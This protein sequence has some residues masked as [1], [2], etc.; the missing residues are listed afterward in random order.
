LVLAVLAGAVAVGSH[1]HT[2]QPARHDFAVAQVQSLKSSAILRQERLADPPGTLIR[3][4]NGNSVVTLTDGARTALFNGPQREFTEPS[5]TTA[6][7]RTNAYVRLAPRPWEEGGAEAPWFQPWLDEMLSTKKPDLLEVI[8]QYLRDAP[9]RSEKSIRYRGDASFG[10]VDTNGVS[11][12]ERSDFFQYLGIPYTFVDGVRV[13]PEQARYG[14]VDSS[15]FVRL[16]YGY[17]LGYPLLGGNARGP[18]LPRRAWAISADGPGVAVVGL[19]GTRR[20]DYNRLQPGDLVFFEM[21]G[22]NQLDH[23]GMYLGRDNRGAHRFVSSRKQADGPTF[24]DLGGTSSL[25]DGGLY[26][27]AW[28]SARRI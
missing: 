25:D 4:G 21:E 20:T 17:R 13:T 26:S 18:G 12:L 8:S 24:G 5:T 27:R 10:P 14:T 15:G 28:R 22:D 9:E 19:T 7:I 11:R 16:V 6:V 2:R 3:D 23:V 1:V